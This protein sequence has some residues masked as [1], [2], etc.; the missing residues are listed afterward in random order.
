MICAHSLNAAGNRHEL[1][2]HLRAVAELAGE[3]ARAFDGDQFGYYLG[4]WH[5]LGKFNPEFQAY[6]LACEQ[7]PTALVAV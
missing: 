4:L 6:L 7:E 3:Y 1:V 2:A 5:D